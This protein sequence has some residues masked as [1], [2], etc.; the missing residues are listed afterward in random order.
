VEIKNPYPMKLT[1]NL[2]TALLLTPQ[3]S[4]IAEYDTI[5]AE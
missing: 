4:S 1:L 3:A 2:L 5:I